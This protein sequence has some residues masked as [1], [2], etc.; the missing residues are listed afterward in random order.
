[1]KSVD[2]GELTAEE[3]GVDPNGQDNARPNT[4]TTAAAQRLAERQAVKAQVVKVGK[5]VGFEDGES[6]DA[7]FQ[8]RYGKS[9]KDATTADLTKYLGVLEDVAGS[10]TNQAAAVADVENS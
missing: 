3:M 6:L 2:G 8:R 9:S 5:T 4:N 10:T 1:V 7:D